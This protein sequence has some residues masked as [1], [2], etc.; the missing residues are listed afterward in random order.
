MFIPYLAQNG[1]VVGDEAAC[2]RFGQSNIT[3]VCVC[4]C[5]PQTSFSNKDTNC[6]LQCERRPWNNTR[7]EGRGEPLWHKMADSREDLVWNSICQ[8]DTGCVGGGIV[9]LLRCI[10]YTIKRCVCSWL[11]AAWTPV[12]FTT[13]MF[14][15]RQKTVE[16]DK[17]L[18]M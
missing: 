15:R 11:T 16:S 3:V 9:S 7:P 13:F 12:H 4:V 17:I 8:A 2:N 1:C 18:Q 14:H 6:P 10:H 5:V